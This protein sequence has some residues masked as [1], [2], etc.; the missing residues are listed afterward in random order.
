M[1]DQN[2]QLDIDV[3]AIKFIMLK[4]FNERYYSYSINSLDSQ[5][6]IEREMIH[7]LFKKFDTKKDLKIIQLTKRFFSFIYVVETKEIIELQNETISEQD[8]VNLLKKEMNEGMIQLNT[9]KEFNINATFDRLKTS[10]IDLY[11]SLIHI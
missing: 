2:C 4:P 11:L 6:L 1:K 9:K 5:H 3:S 10:T 8:I 7:E